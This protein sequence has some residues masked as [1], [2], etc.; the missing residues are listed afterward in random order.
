MDYVTVRELREKS[1]EIWQRVESGEE[2][3]ITRNGK[4]FALLVHTAPSA[5]EDKLRALR[6]QAFGRAWE[7]LSRQARSTGAAQLTDEEIQAEVEAVREERRRAA[8]GA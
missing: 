2:F 4:P 1:G 3:V 6:L 5:V 8:R 7:A